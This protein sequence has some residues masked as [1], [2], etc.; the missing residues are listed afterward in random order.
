MNLYLPG[1]STRVFGGVPTGEANAQ[2]EAIKIAIGIFLIHIIYMYV[3]HKLLT[4][5]RLSPQQVLFYPLLF[6][7]MLS[8]SLA[9]MELLTRVS[10]GHYLIGNVKHIPL[11]EVNKNQTKN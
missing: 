1:P 3:G 2:L 9:T 4:V 7:L 10:W 6:L 8:L 11:H 5:I